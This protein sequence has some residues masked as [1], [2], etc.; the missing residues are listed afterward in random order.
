MSDA[1]VTRYRPRASPPG[2]P[3]ILEIG[4]AATDGVLQ[5]GHRLR[6]DIYATS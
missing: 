4:L 2:E 5:P 3:T 6:I 1:A